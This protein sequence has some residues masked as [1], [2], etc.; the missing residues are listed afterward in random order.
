MWIKPCYSSSWGCCIPDQI[1]NSFF[2][3]Y[4]MENGEESFFS[5]IIFFNIAWNWCDSIEITLELEEFWYKKVF[6]PIICSPQIEWLSSGNKCPIHI[7]TLN[8]WLTAIIIQLIRLHLGGP[9]H[10]HESHVVTYFKSCHT[11]FASK[12]AYTSL[13]IIRSRAFCSPHN[14]HW[15]IDQTAEILMQRIKLL[16]RDAYQSNNLN[17]YPKR[18]CRIEKW[19]YF[20]R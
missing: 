1:Q 6:V 13:R 2:R 18:C 8:F 14:T 7:S 9:P 5:H 16:K 4:K 12:S 10:K 15:H 17:F 11:C 19:W 20:D 3:T